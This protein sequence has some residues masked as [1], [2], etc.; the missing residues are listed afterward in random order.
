MTW[1]VCVVF[2]AS[3]SAEA[4]CEGSEC[5]VLR[6][7]W[8]EGAAVKEDVRVGWGWEEDWRGRECEDEV[9]FIALLGLVGEGLRC[10]AETWESEVACV[11][12]DLR[13]LG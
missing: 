10:E 1:S 5:A 2:A 7:R 11:A 12:S 4:S 13:A 8:S 9:R 6:R 3:G